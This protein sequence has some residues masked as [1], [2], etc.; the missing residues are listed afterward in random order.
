MWWGD[1]VPANA[2][3]VQLQPHL[4]ASKHLLLHPSTLPD[5][6]H[7]H[8]DAPLPALV[9]VNRNKNSRL[10]E[11]MSSRYTAHRWREAGCNQITVEADVQ[12][13]T[14]MAPTCFQICILA[15]VPH[16]LPERQVSGASQEGE[17]DLLRKLHTGAAVTSGSALHPISQPQTL[18]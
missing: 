15:A 7:L 6:P 13:W 14:Q 12:T 4:E 8:T 16:C 17:P 2:H 1:G 11:T 5:T 18:R 9:C 3:S 10:M